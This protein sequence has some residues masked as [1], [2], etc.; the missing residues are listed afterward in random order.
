MVCFATLVGDTGS[1]FLAD[2]SVYLNG[3]ILSII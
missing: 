1:V 3:I 2:V